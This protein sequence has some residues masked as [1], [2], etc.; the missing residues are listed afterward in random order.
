MHAADY[1][2]NIMTLVVKSRYVVCCFPTTH[3]IVACPTQFSASKGP[4]VWVPCSKS[5]DSLERTVK[6]L[7]S[8]IPNKNLLPGACRCKSRQAPFDQ[9]TSG[10][11]GCDCPAH[12]N[13]PP[14]LPTAVGRIYHMRQLTKE[15]AEL[16][17]WW[18]MFSIENLNAYHI[19]ELFSH[20]FTSNTKGCLLPLLKAEGLISGMYGAMS[21]SLAAS[22]YNWYLLDFELTHK[23]RTLE[24]RSCAN[25]TFMKIQTTALTCL[26]TLAGTTCHHVNLVTVHQVS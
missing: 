20:I 11:G 4:G 24:V 8:G 5:L 16:C 14:H 15:V 9:N 1:S 13:Y 22:S 23:G 3:R 25:H 2:A 7:F 10:W 12:W 17:M 19:E 26:S 21:T 6:A 18:P